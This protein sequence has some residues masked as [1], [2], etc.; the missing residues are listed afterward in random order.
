MGGDVEPGRCRTFR[1]LLAPESGVNRTFRYPDRHNGSRGQ[2]RSQRRALS[3]SDADSNGDSNRDEH[4]AADSYGQRHT[5]DDADR[6][7][8]PH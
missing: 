2:H 6:H 5:Y 3:A 1:Y 4:A 8:Y 7:A